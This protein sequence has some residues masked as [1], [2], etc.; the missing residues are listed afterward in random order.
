M[1]CLSINL[2]LKT[3]KMIVL[4]NEIYEGIMIKLK[5]NADL[6]GLKSGA[7]I[8]LPTDQEGN[9]ENS[10]WARRLKDS[11]VDNCVEV[12]TENKKSNKKRDES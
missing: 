12:F 2:T 6:G 4:L 8:S 1:A 3:V 11:K 9:I 7:I 5:L 10:F